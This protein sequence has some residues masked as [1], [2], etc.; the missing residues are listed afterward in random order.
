MQAHNPPLR[1]GGTLP[2]VTEP[3]RVSFSP[4][5]IEVSAH[6]TDLASADELIRSINALKLLLRPSSEIEKPDEEAAN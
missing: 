4:G 2:Q 3:Y 6:L 5:S 1:H